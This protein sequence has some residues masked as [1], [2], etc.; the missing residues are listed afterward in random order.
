MDFKSDVPLCVFGLLAD[1]VIENEIFF[2]DK[3]TL[4]VLHSHATPVFDTVMRFFTRA[5]SALALIPFN[6]IVFA[7]L[8][9]RR[10]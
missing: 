5:G 8:V 3:P 7:V 2:F 9:W 6:A 4:V 10:R 1:D